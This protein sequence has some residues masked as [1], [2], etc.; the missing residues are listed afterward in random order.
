MIYMSLGPEF[1]YTKKPPR[2]PSEF[3][4]ECRCPTRGLSYVQ[5]RHFLLE[6]GV[7]EKAVWVDDVCLRTQRIPLAF[8]PS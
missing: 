7:F 6:K 3:S 4:C 5:G 8:R 1:A 2:V